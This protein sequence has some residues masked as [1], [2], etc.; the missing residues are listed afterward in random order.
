MY[1]ATTTR[2]ST[3]GYTFKKVQDTQYIQVVYKK[4]SDTVFMF[5]GANGQLIPNKA[6][7]FAKYGDSV[8]IAIVPNAGYIIDSVLVNG[9]KQQGLRNLGD[10]IKF[11]PI[12]ANQRIQAYFKKA[13]YVL[14]S[15][16]LS[17]QGNTNGTITRSDTTGGVYN[18][19]YGDSVIFTLTPNIGFALDSITL[20]GVLI[21]NQA[22]ID[23]LS[24]TLVYK[25]VLRGIYRSDSIVVKYK[26]FTF[27]FIARTANG[28]TI[29]GFYNNLSLKSDTTYKI[30]YGDTVR[31]TVTVANGYIDTLRIDTNRLLYLQNYPTNVYNYTISNIQK[32][33]TIKVGRYAAQVPNVPTI[34]NAIPKPLSARIYF[35]PSTANTNDAPI[36]N[37]IVTSIPFNTTA[38]G[39]GSSITQAQSANFSVNDTSYSIFVTGLVAGVV[40]NFTMVAV[41]TA[42][43]SNAS[44][45]SNSILIPTL[46]SY[47]II[48]SWG[49]NGQ[50]SISNLVSVKPPYRVLFNPNTG[51]EADSVYVDGVFVT[52]DSL[53]GYTFNN[54]SADRYVYVTFK[55]KTFTII[56]VV[57][58]INAGVVTALNGVFSVKYGDSLVLHIQTQPDSLVYNAAGNIVIERYRYFIDTLF[59]NDQFVQTNINTQQYNYVLKNIVG[60]STVKIKCKLVRIN[61]QVYI[62]FVDQLDSIGKSFNYPDSANYYL[63]RDLDFKNPQHYST[64]VIDS[65]NH[66]KDSGWRPIIF[67]GV[68]DGQNHSISNVYIGARKNTYYWYSAISNFNT[69]NGFFGYVGVGDTIKNLVLKNIVY[70]NQ[71]DSLGYLESA[72]LSSYGNQYNLSLGGFFVGTN[73]GYIENCSVIGQLNNLFTKELSLFNSLDVGGFVY[74][75]TSTGVILNCV[76]KMYINDSSANIIT[77]QNSFDLDAK[78]YNVAGFVAINGGNISN[79]YTNFT[80][81]NPPIINTPTSSQSGQYSSA[82]TDARIPAGFIRKSNGGTI[83]NCYTFSN[84][85]APFYALKTTGNSVGVTITNSYTNALNFVDKTYINRNSGNDLTGNVYKNIASNNDSAVREILKTNV[86]Y[87][88]KAGDFPYLRYSNDTTQLLPNQ[89]KN[90]RVIV[91]TGNNTKIDTVSIDQ[92]LEKNTLLYTPTTNYYY[93]SIFINNTYYT[94]DSNFSFTYTNVGF[95]EI[96]SIVIM[97]K[98]I[99]IPLNITYIGLNTAP[100]QP[101]YYD[102]KLKKAPRILPPFTYKIDSI[103]I[104]NTYITKDSING[105]TFTNINAQL[106]IKIKYIKYANLV[107]ITTYISKKP[108]YIDTILYNIFNKNIEPVKINNPY[109][110]YSD[111]GL[112]LKSNIFKM[113][114]IFKEGVLITKDST[115]S[116]TFNNNVANASNYSIYVGKAAPIY[117][118]YID[119]LDSIGVADIYPNDGYYYLNRDLDF[120]NPVHYS[121]GVIDSANHIKDSGWRA[122]IFNGVFD[123][124]NHSISNVLIGPRLNSNFRF[125][126]NYKPLNGFFSYLG[127]KDTIKNLHLKNAV[128]DDKTDFIYRIGN[129]NFLIRDYNM[130]LGGFF[131]GT[132]NGYIENC[133]VTGQLNNLFKRTSITLNNDPNFEIPTLDVAGFVYK[134][135]ATGVIN[136]CATNVYIQDST[137]YA[138]VNT[139]GVIDTANQVFYNFAGFVSYNQGNIAHSYTNFNFKIP[140]VIS[141]PTSNEGSFNGFNQ[142]DNKI[143]AGFLRLSKNGVISNCY[144]YS[145]TNTSFYSLKFSASYSVYPATITNSYINSLNFVNRVIINTNGGN[146]LTRF[147]TKNIASNR[148]SA[149]RDTLKNN[150]Y[151][152]KKIGY[153]PYLRNSNDTTQLLPN[154]IKYIPVVYKN[155]L[156]KTY[157]DSALLDLRTNYANSIAFNQSGLKIDSIF[158]NNVFYAKDSFKNVLLPINNIL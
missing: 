143:P 50:L 115:Q 76:S 121:T 82:Y 42:G 147:P 142:I 149:V 72:D 2:D 57:A 41:N 44:N 116:Y 77:E 156:P 89:I 47:N 15:S 90:L 75:N 137:G 127:E 93:D 28:A 91:K 7:G 148:E 123:G 125:L 10:T 38:T 1:N 94:T 31:F 124:Q 105:I 83:N 37:Y 22:I 45:T 4:I 133:T 46:N 53:V 132:N 86:N 152:Y 43:S 40:Y 61:Q 126:F 122:I 70:D 26:S 153:F 104:G 48:P 36:Q 103:F 109:L 138:I 114:S 5:A 71:A 101:V 9:V 21:N 107:L 12:T 20:N 88:K 78:S 119:E 79:S 96:D 13:V 128:Y 59:I 158:I 3:L 108:K 110:L 150:V 35:K 54:L 154:Q 63:V 146:D 33:Y 68:F 16:L 113:D 92:R 136:N 34:L 118:N 134:N 144:T 139:G 80:F 155:I 117:I 85:N 6:G 60:N 52:K 56:P 73:N 30:N 141:T 111:V 84:T 140:P 87:L 67:N 51:Y 23:T 102:F 66:I 24:R 99:F 29:T 106:P 74:N 11:Y 27:N 151:Y 8:F 25:Y 129:N 112:S 120:N 81:K 157:T 58:P 62:S 130:P 145:N 32:D 135:A 19:F 131:I 18:H 95:Y 100:T 49:T 39:I 65:T 55:R 69:L 97:Q 14:K 64:G 17:V 98:S